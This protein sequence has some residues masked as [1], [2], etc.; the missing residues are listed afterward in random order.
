M[1]YTYV[2]ESLAS[3]PTRYIGHTANLRQRLRDHRAGKCPH[4]AQRGP[5]NLK[6]YLAFTTLEHA[7]RFERYL[8]SGSGHAFAKRHFW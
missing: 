2:L 4:T 7:Q 6:L 5:W 1:Y 3:P 8:K